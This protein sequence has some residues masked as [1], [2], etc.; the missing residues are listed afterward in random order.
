MHSKIS[1]MGH[2]ISKMIRFKGFFGKDFKSL[3]FFTLFRYFGCMDLHNIMSMVHWIV[4][5]D[6]VGFHIT[7][8]G[9]KNPFLVH[10]INITTFVKW[11]DLWGHTFNSYFTY[12]WVVC[13]S[14]TCGTSEY[15]DIV[16]SKLPVI[17]LMMCIFPLN[18]KMILHEIY[19]QDNC[20][21]SIEIK[22]KQKL[23][24]WIIRTQIKKII[25]M[26]IILR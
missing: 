14:G 9:D 24:V 6:T 1:H 22:L 11:G 8:K 15:N 26:Y 4:V 13:S 23:I 16:V 3:N 7:K 19:W 17:K 18:W 12:I 10:F 25:P 20:N 21:L 2:P 5:E